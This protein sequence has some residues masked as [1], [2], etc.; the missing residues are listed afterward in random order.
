MSFVEIGRIGKPHGIRGEVRI[1]LHWEASE[2]LQHTDR[3]LVVKADGSH[4]ELMLQSVRGSSAALIARFAGVD[5]RD[6]AEALRGAT[7]SV[8][9][10]VLPPL[11]PGE[12][13]LCDLVGAEV[14]GP[15]GVV[16][17]VAEVRIHPSVDSMI[18]RTADGRMLEQPIADAWVERVDTEAGRVELS[19]T[20]GLL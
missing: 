3:V 19:S 6:D 4:R 18:I 7:V 10:D 15:H 9:R 1:R 11:E 2:S 16:G 17:T 5:T 20:E 12:Y 14:V 8:A 13:Y